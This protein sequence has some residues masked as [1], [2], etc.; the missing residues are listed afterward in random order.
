MGNLSPEEQAKLE[1]DCK[2]EFDKI[3]TD[4]SGLIDKD[5]FRKL[6]EK[7]A[8]NTGGEMASEKDIDDVF[9]EFDTDNSGKI[10]FD[11]VMKEWISFSFLVGLSKDK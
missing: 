1:K 5:E 3:D 2:E 8:K 10:S 11:E 9:K 6:I 4:K 7:I